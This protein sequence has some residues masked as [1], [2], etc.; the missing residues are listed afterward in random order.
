MI[1]LKLLYKLYAFKID[2][3]RNIILYIVVKLEGGEMLSSALCRIFLEYHQIE[4]GL[5][6]YGD[7]FNLNR[8]A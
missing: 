2:C 4:T 7:C 5:Y 3:L 8:I 6:N 1:L